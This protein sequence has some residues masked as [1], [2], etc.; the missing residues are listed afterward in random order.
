M[1]VNWIDVLI[2]G[3]VTLSTLIG[4]V[5]GLTREILSLVIWALSLFLA[6]RHYEVVVPHLEPWLPGSTLPRVG[7]I[8]ILTL[9]LALF[10]GLVGYLVTSVLELV[11]LAMTTS[12]L[13]GLFGALRG[14]LILGM[15]AFLAALT[16]LP[17]QEAWRN[18]LLVGRFQVL[19]ERLLEQI[20]S[21][22]EGRVRTL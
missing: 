13:G 6:W 11:G 12:L 19:A 14:A 3:M 16:P 9:G 5:R 2:L 21:E 10:G 17:E 8:L 20:P 7:A 18:S 22:L 1:R 15:L 4:L